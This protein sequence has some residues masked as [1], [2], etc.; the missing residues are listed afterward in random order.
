[1]RMLQFFALVIALVTIG[2]PGLAGAADKATFATEPTTNSGAKWRIGYYE[3]GPYTNYQ[4][5]LAATVRGLMKLGW[6]DAATLPPPPEDETTAVLWK[7][8]ASQNSKFVEF[9]ADAH[10]SANWED[11]K[12]ERIATTMFN[13]L[14][15]AGDIDL[16]IAMGTRAAKVL[17]N[18]KH[19]TPT[20]VMSTSDPISTGIIKSVE[21]SGFEHVH[22]G[23]DPRRHERQLLIF[24]EAIG[25]KKLGVAFE[26]SVNGRSYAAMHVVDR[27]SLSRGFEVATCHTQSDVS[28]T[29]VA[30]ASVINC[31]KQ[32]AT[33]VDAIYLTQQGG[34]TKRSIPKLVAIADEHNIP[35][36]SQTG[37]SEVAL[38]VLMSLSRAA[39]RYV[40]EFNAAT[41]AKIMNGA[42]PNQIDQLF[43]EP[44]KIAINLHTAELI[45]FDPPLV[46]LGAADEIF[47]DIASAK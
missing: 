3:G 46:L 22:A 19:G 14:N 32:L 23:V 4:Q 12:S 35:T 20:V 8:L 9:V 24:H 29:S 27:L 26:N 37:S 45:G 15:N 34:V 13:R 6:I 33:E 7:W 1:M 2:A 16:I 38:G 47:E 41:M 30:E 43:E 28:D 18:N 40:V 11:A 39:Y 31:F 17:A 44:P 42:K 21:D 25:F 36:F 10:Y 5:T